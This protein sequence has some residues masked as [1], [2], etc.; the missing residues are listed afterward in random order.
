MLHIRLELTQKKYKAATEEEAGELHDLVTGTTSEIGTLFPDPDSFQRIFWAEQI[1]Y[2][3]L[4]EKSA[5]RWHLLIVQWTL[6]IR[7]KSFKGY[8]A[9][10][11]SGLINLPSKR[12]LYNY[13]HCIA[14]ELGFQPEALG[15]LVEECKYRGMFSE[16]EPW[17]AYVGLLQDEI[18][19]KDNLVYCASTNRLVGYTALD[20]ISNQIMQF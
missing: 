11:E 3:Q 5:M 7:S 17:K 2:N 9:M 4:K 18:K 13:S 1:K 8:E 15:L 10:R 19:L 20:E 14:S 6:F 16:T 12:T